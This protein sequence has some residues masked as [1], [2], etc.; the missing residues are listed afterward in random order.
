MIKHTKRFMVCLNTPYEEVSDK[1]KSENINFKLILD[2]H[3]HLESIE[4]TVFGF[5]SF[6][7][8]SNFLPILKRPPVLWES[9]CTIRNIE[10]NQKLIFLD[11]KMFSSGL[12]M[13]KELDANSLIKAANLEFRFNNTIIFEKS[14]TKHFGNGS[15]LS[16]LLNTFLSTIP[17]YVHEP[18]LISFITSLESNDYKSFDSYIKSNRLLT[19]E[20]KKVFTEFSVYL[21]EIEPEIKYTIKNDKVNLRKIKDKSVKD[22]LSR[23]RFLLKYFGTKNINNFLDDED[24]V[25]LQCEAV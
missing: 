7:I 18:T 3:Q 10:L 9:S 20:N 4:N 11:A 24:N 25:N 6:D 5:N 8:M 17:G 21:K 22:S 12:I 16:I 23:I 13:F 15:R 1:L 14:T 2:P 19:N